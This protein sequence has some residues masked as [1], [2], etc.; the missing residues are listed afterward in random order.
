LEPLWTRTLGQAAMVAWVV[1][2]I[3]GWFAI[4]KI[5]EIEV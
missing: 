4:K 3:A 2:L 5:V 1:M